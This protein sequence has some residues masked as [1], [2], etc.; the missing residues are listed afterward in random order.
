[1][2]IVDHSFPIGG[3]N[4]GVD[5]MWAITKGQASS[6]SL[7]VDGF[8]AVSG[9]LVMR[10][11]LNSDNVLSYIWKRFLRIVPAFW[12]CLLVTAFAIA[13]VAWL[14][15]H[16]S[17]GGYFS[18]KGDGSYLSYLRQNFLL[19][20]R[21]WNINNLLSKVPYNI[22]KYPIAF[23]GSLWTLIYEFKAYLGLAIIGIMTRAKRNHSLAIFVMLAVFLISMTAYVV[24]SVT[25]LDPESLFLPFRDVQWPALASF[26]SAGALYYLLSSRVVVS[27]YGVLVSLCAVGIALYARPFALVGP[28]FLTYAIISTALLVDLSV[29]DRKIGDPS[30]GIYIYAFPVGQVLA[31]GLAYKFGFIFF[32]VATFVVSLIF[33]FGS[34]KLIEHPLQRL[35][36]VF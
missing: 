33:A 19:N 26:F 2:V 12:V 5:P 16:G 20:M 25:S 35:K 34:W 27:W 17:I 28:I 32:V 1:M 10:S 14:I 7:A 21:Q 30:Y 8:F 29:V 3:F 13:P 31:D 36:R 11:L 22:T 15:E 9:F 4:G 23:D 6:G 24:Q 18:F